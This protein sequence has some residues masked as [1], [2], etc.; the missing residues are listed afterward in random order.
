MISATE[1]VLSVINSPVR[2]ITAKVELYEGSALVNTFNHT[3]RLKAIT[4]ERV[5]DESKFFGFTVCQKLNIKLID[6]NRELNITTAN[7]FKVYFNDIDCFP[8]FNVTEVHRDENTNELSI[9]AYDLLY[10]AVKMTVDEVD[11][12]FIQPFEDGEQVSYTLGQFTTAVAVVLGAYGLVYK[13]IGPDETCFDTYYEEGANF[14]GTETIRSAIDAIAEVTQTICFINQNNEI[15]FKRLNKS[16]NADLEITKASYIDLDSSTNRRLTTIT[17][18]TEL[19]NNLTAS[20]GEIGTTQF[21]RDN[22]F[23]NMRDDVGTLLDNAVAAIGGLTINQFEC[24]WRGNFLLEI[25]DKIALT[26]KDDDIVFSFILDDTIEYNGAFSEK[27]RWSYTN[28]DGETSANPTT[29]GEA[30]KQTYAKVDKAN[31][32]IDLVA[33][34][35]NINKSAIAA[36]QVNTEGINASV[37]KV[38]TSTKEAIDGVTGEIEELKSRVDASM[39]AEDVKIEI[40]KELA[41]GVET[42]TTKTGFTFDE[43]GLT[44]EK[45]NSEIKTQI[46]ED[47]MQVFRHDEA[48]LTANNKGVDAANLHATTY[49]WIGKNSRFE[50]YGDDRTGCFWVGGE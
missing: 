26:T 42:V 38:E 21:I 36:L 49:L 12:G 23:W 33:S 2:T 45:S 24:S 28:N 4:I 7:S 6:I 14:E 9:T 30:I 35:V 43:T 18:T 25:G 40:Q 31:K 32:Q 1:K 46:T 34:E 37:Q 41:T 22:P 17:H 27:T 47:G 5:G 15:V 3:D 44:V 20:N 13:N 48:V 11:N 16:G 29:L 19:G 8:F 10:E 39:T 50:D